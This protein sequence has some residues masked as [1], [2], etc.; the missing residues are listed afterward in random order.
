M[1]LSIFTY[2]LPLLVARIVS[3]AGP[4]SALA[5]PPDARS[6]QVLTNLQGGAVKARRRLGFP[7]GRSTSPS[8]GKAS[9]ATSATNHRH[10]PQTIRK[11]AFMP[12]ESDASSIGAV[13]NNA[14]QNMLSVLNKVRSSLKSEGGS[15]LK[16]QLAKK[17]FAAFLTFVMLG[18]VVNSSFMSVAW[19]GF[20][21]QTGLSPLAPG[22]WKPFLAVYAGFM[23]MESFLKPIRLA[24]SIAIA[25]A[26]DSAMAWLQKKL[27]GSKSAT[28]G[29][30][31]AGII[32][33]SCGLFAG[34]VTLASSLAGVPVFAP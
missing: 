3:G 29:V 21:L 13:G 1:K 16:E 10:S 26:A 6:Q 23:A 17:G 31:L 14:P 12:M 2:V 18:N 34:G 24:V 25:P 22:Q 33:A 15:T 9:S 20:S 32:A 4:V 30:A 19:Y 11:V 5:S 27:N 7:F 8:L 28:V